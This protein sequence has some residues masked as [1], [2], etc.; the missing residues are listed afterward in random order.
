MDDECKHLLPIGHCAYCKPPPEGV[1][2]HGYRTKGGHAYHNDRECDWLR[3]GHDRSR[4]QGKDIHDAVRVAWADVKPGELEPCE[5]CC[6]SQ[7]L[8]RHG[9]QGISPAERTEASP[10]GKPCQVR[11]GVD[12]YP[13]LLTWEKAPRD[14]GLWWARVKYRRGGKEIVVIKNQ[15]DLR[16]RQ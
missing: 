13:G 5:F 10:S 15:N 9:K 12:W 2:P 11:D 1:L 16:P 3:K 7:W 14:D 6:T 4:R 8:R